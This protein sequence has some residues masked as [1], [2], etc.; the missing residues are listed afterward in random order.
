MKVNQLRNRHSALKPIDF[1]LIGTVLIY[2]ALA[3]TLWSG[4]D[5][6]IKFYREYQ[7]TEDEESSL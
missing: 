7:V 1:H 6:F 3:L 2:M 4:V 5:Y